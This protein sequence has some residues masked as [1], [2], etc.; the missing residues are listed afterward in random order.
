MLQIIFIGLSIQII[1]ACLLVDEVLHRFPGRHLKI[2]NE[3][4]PLCIEIT[5]PMIRQIKIIDAT[6]LS[7]ARS[8]KTH[9]ERLVCRY[10]YSRLS[11]LISTPMA[12]HDNRVRHLRLY[13]SDAYS[14]RYQDIMILNPILINRRQAIVHLR[15]ETPVVFIT[16]CMSLSDPGSVERHTE[17]LVVHLPHIVPLMP[18]FILTAPV[19]L[20]STRY[21]L[22][23]IHIKAICRSNQKR[24]THG[25]HLVDGQLEEMGSTR[26]LQVLC[27]HR[28]GIR[29][30]AIVEHIAD[31]GNIAI[32]LNI[33]GVTNNS[34]VIELTGSGHIPHIYIP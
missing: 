19:K 21:L 16:H 27:F 22:D 31:I 20:I 29:D 14:V 34:G 9:I 32:I 7:K 33:S 1:L 2:T 28:A 3:L 18:I 6:I 30:I 13:S 24:T 5:L 25:F 10:I 12:K 26:H 15:N 4:C 11:I 23:N 8:R 17:C